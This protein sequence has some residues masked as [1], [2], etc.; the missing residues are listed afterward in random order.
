MA[1]DID[2]KTRKHISKWKIIQNEM[3]NPADII[4]EI[5][6]IVSKDI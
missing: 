6:L 3:N 2:E 5:T 1:T 4:E